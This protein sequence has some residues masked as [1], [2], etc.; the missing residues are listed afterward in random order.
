MNKNTNLEDLETFL[1][2][3]SKIIKHYINGQYKLVS[4][5]LL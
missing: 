5:K 3:H 4:P 1:I 2:N